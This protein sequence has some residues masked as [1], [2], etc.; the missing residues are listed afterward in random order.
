[1]ERPNDLPNPEN[2]VSFEDVAEVEV[3][4][5]GDAEQRQV[6][7][8][9]R[10]EER[11]N[12]GGSMQELKPCPCCGSSNG[13]YVLQD[14]KYGEWSVFCDICKTSLHNE[15]HCDTRDD[16][17]SAWNRRAERTC[18]NLNPPSCR[19]FECSECGESSEFTPGFMPNYCPN[20]GARVIEEGV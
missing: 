14:E 4:N 5:H 9:R 2:S 17:I 18:R 20:C 16:A 13:L 7:L 11:A 15:N 8:R 1:M 12:Q 6:A 3:I 19:D 10:E